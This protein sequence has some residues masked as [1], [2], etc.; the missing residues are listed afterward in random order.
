MDF[1]GDF[2]AAMSLGQSPLATSGRV[3]SSGWAMLQQRQD[4]IREGGCDGGCDND[5]VHRG[6]VFTVIVMRSL[7]S[8]LLSTFILF[9]LLTSWWSS[10]QW[11]GCSRDTFRWVREE[12]WIRGVAPGA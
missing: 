1:G 11:F 10:F 12:D 3:G 2:K 8:F 9:S 6:L 7:S 5:G 4:T